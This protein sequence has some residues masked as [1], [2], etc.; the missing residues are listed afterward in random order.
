M[1][2]GFCLMLWTGFDQHFGGLE[3]TRQFIHAQPGWERLPPEHL[4]RLA[5]DRIFA[6][7]LYP[8]TLAGAILLYTPPLA[9]AVWRLSVALTLPTRWLLVG[10][11]AGCSLACLYWSGSKAG[12]LIAMV[13][14]GT[15]LLSFRVGR[16]WKVGLLA[17]LVLV[18]TAGFW[19][20]FAGYL[21][22][23]APSV[24]ARM[25]YWRAA[26]RTL[27]EH[28]LTGT[29]PGTFSVAYR[30]IKPPE[31]EMARLA[32]NDYLEQGSDSGVPGAVLY[33]GLVVGGLAG[34]YGRSREDPLWFGAWLGL[35]GWSLQG[36]SEFGLYVPA[37]GWTAFWGL[38]W[39]WGEAASGFRAQEVE[40]EQR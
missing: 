9:V 15:T 29:G 21:Q 23:G 40:S 10:V 4:K 11:L 1:L 33:L 20:R 17:A 6:T 37:L 25:D 24:S 16:R 19:L 14:A 5:S 38:G 3:A 39:L 28:P 30:R 32:H 31:A 36:I 12:W 26:W 18:G 34:L 13:M 7:L 2:P 22:R 27:V 8:N 35:L